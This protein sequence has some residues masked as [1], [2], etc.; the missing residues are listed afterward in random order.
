MRGVRGSSSSSQD[1]SSDDGDDDESLP[2]LEG[3]E[4]S[5]QL[6]EAAGLEP[7]AEER[8]DEGADQS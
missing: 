1:S 7:T 6:E 5:A 3:L 8:R 4:T 2:E